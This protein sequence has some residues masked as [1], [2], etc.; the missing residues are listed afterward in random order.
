MGRAEGGL[1]SRNRCK[2]KTNRRAGAKWGL[3]SYRIG[4]DGI[5][6]KM[7][8]KMVSWRRIRLRHVD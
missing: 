8:E 6:S 2:T 7:K 1:E 4:Y 3:V 5:A